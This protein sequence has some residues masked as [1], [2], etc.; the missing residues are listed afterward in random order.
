MVNDGECVGVIQC[1]QE[2]SGRPHRLHLNVLAEL[3]NCFAQMK[4][5]KVR[6]IIV[7]LKRNN[8]RACSGISENYSSYSSW[9]QFLAMEK[10]ESQLASF[11]FTYCSK[12][13]TTRRDHRS[14][15]NRELH[16]F[17]VRGCMCRCNVIDVYS[18]P[19]K[20]NSSPLKEIP[21]QNERLVF[22]SHHFSGAFAVKLRGCTPGTWKWMTMMVWF[23]WFSFSLGWFLALPV[24]YI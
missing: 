10:F 22:Q 14:D 6:T 4:P 7:S 15:H 12:I 2:A 19:W 20:F 3:F 24:M 17:T 9:Q 8:Q 1:P 21:S 13:W 16:I 18:T 23:R 11:P 5:Q